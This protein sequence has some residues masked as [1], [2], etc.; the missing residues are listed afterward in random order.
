MS[1]QN[2]AQAAG[3]S[4]FEKL[5][6]LVAEVETSDVEKTR[7][8]YFDWCADVDIEDQLDSV[9]GKLR[10]TDIEMLWVVLS[11]IR[12]EVEIAGELDSE[13]PSDADDE[14]IVSALSDYGFCT[15]FQ[16]DVRGICG[17]VLKKWNAD[18]ENT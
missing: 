9:C 3:S 8:D 7:Q 6:R 16:D 5:F 2:V 18:S 12:R 10:M 17:E 4:S 13:L 15:A 11:V 14:H 1:P